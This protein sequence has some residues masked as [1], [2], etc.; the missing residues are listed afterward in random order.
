VTPEDGPYTPRGDSLVRSLS[1][2][3]VF[4][5]FTNLQSR[6]HDLVGTPESGPRAIC[7]VGN[8]FTATIQLL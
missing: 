4:R 3:R 6:G 7:V 1:H 5:T 2:L 8:K